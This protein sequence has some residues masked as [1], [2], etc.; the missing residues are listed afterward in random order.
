M[1]NLQVVLSG[2]CAAHKRHAWTTCCS[3]PR[4]TDEAMLRDGNFDR[5][6]VNRA[7]SVGWRMHHVYALSQKT[8]RTRWFK[9]SADVCSTVQNESRSPPRYREST[10]LVRFPKSI[11]TRWFE[12]STDVCPVVR[13]GSRSPQWCGALWRRQGTIRKCFVKVLRLS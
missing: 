4:S 9:K 6:Y 1:S 7:F 3:N 12:K 2:K 13:N 10:M 8:V 5:W 11:G